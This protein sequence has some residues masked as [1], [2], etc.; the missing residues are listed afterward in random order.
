[1]KTEL[2]SNIGEFLGTFILTFIGCS[3]VAFDLL[4]KAFS[5]LFQVACIWGVGVVLAIYVVKSFS[6]A[7]LNP[8]V[9]IGFAV[10]KEISVKQLIHHFFAQ[11]S[12][13]IVAGLLVFSLFITKIEEYELI[14]G[15]KQSQE[16][17]AIF[18]EFF[19]NPISNDLKELSLISAFFYELT[20]TFI[21]MLI[22]L[23]LRISKNL[24][25]V[26]PFF[27]GLTVAALILWIAPFTQCGINP[28]R[29]FGPRLVAYYFK[30]G[31]QAFPK[32]RLSFLSV[33]IFAPLLGAVIAAGSFAFFIKRVTQFGKSRKRQHSM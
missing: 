8:A 12:G 21:L 11:L 3:A 33:Y 17:A 29:D 14:N 18:G 15:L 7:C 5:S 6:K 25:R 9:S 30:W 16:T 1:M 23:F 24:S 2:K 20:G 28:A 26:S 22:I 31:D 4:F 27:I 19:P 10:L 13:G 32:P